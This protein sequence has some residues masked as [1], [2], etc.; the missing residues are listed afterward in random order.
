MKERFRDRVRKFFQLESWTSSNLALARLLVI[1]LMVLGVGIVYVSML[2]HYASGQN[3]AHVAQESARVVLEPSATNVTDMTAT[4]S[5][6]V[7]VL[8]SGQIHYGLTSTYGMQS[9]FQAC[10]EYDQH[11]MNLTN[12]LPG[13]TYH[14]RVTS[15]DA[16]N[17]MYESFDHTF[18]TTLNG[19][20]VTPTNAPPTPTLVPFVTP[21]YI[22]VVPD[23]ITGRV[24]DYGDNTLYDKKQIGDY[25]PA[26]YSQTLPGFIQI[27]N[28]IFENWDCYILAD[29]FDACDYTKIRVAQFNTWDSSDEYYYIIPP[30]SRA[31]ATRSNCLFEGDRRKRELEQRL[32]C[33]QLRGESIQ[34]L[35]G[36]FIP[37][38]CDYHPELSHCVTEVIPVLEL[39]YKSPATSKPADAGWWANVVC[40]WQTCLGNYWVPIELD[41][42]RRFAE[43][44]ER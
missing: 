2:D 36:V 44:F 9:A 40:P 16:N 17:V 20:V 34:F 26:D 21:Q 37:P 19:Q 18:T 1:A 30:P 41:D 13:T 22:P 3:S 15:V 35:Y 29:K 12:L 27:E 8:C 43:V 10:C 25:D 23:I 24:V 31:S 38:H 11:V 32:E 4:I 39:K 42:G 33:P 5:W 28:V 7:G 14:Y 6:E